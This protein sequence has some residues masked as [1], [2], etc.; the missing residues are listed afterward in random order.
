MV[1]LAGPMI[2]DAVCGDDF[3]QSVSSIEEAKQVILNRFEKIYGQKPSLWYAL[4]Y[5]CLEDPCGKC[6]CHKFA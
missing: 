1:T 5:Y 6:I 2:I 3:V 4:H